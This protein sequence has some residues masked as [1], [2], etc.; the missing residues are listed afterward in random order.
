MAQTKQKNRLRELRERGTVLSQKDLGLLLG[1]DETTVSRHESG[2]RGMTREQITEYARI[3]RVPSHE[4]F[5][6]PDND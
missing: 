5:V 1:I 3:F 6:R 4:I 2:D